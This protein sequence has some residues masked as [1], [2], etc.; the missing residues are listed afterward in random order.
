MDVTQYRQKDE[1]HEAH[2]KI[3]P[4]SKHSVLWSIPCR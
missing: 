1:T 4:G 3:K 2:A